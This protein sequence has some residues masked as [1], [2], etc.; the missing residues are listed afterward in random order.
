VLSQTIEAVK[1]RAQA[2]LAYGQGYGVSQGFWALVLAITG[3][4]VICQLGLSLYFIARIALLDGSSLVALIM[5]R[6]QMG[7][8]L[9]IQPWESFL[10]WPPFLCASL[11]WTALISL[12][13]RKDNH[14]HRKAFFAKNGD[15]VLTRALATSKNPRSTRE[16][17]LP[18]M[19]CFLSISISSRAIFHHGNNNEFIPTMI[20][21]FLICTSIL[22]VAVVLFTSWCVGLKHIPD[23]SIPLFLRK[24]LSRVSVRRQFDD[25]PP[26][27]KTSMIAQAIKM[28][29]DP[30]SA[31]VKRAAVSDYRSRKRKAVVCAQSLESLTPSAPAATLSRR[32]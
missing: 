13:V 24:I 19:G 28:G 5:A 32:L 16:L 29:V 27:E 9:H 21:A 23:K 30:D 12:G 14:A 25:L 10:T 11:L 17:I 7:D 26:M 1:S 2:C 8:L 3:L 18:A 31:A 20:V 15:T 22:S 6:A 4:A